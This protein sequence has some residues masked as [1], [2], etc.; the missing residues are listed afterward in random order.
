MNFR[1]AS[2]PFRRSAVY[3]NNLV[4]IANARAGLANKVREE[5]YNAHFEHLRKKDLEVIFQYIESSAKQGAVRV[6]NWEWSTPSPVRKL[7][8]EDKDIQNFMMKNGFSYSDHPEC[9][10]WYNAEETKQLA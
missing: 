9:I 4:K 8:F 10:E 1:M 2:V 5:M 3:M 7:L 6:M